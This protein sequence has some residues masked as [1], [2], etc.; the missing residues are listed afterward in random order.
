MS[1]DLA[2]FCKAMDGKWEVVRHEKNNEG[3]ITVHYRSLSNPLVE[4]SHNPYH[5]ENVL[6][7]GTIGRMGFITLGT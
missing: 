7:V 2:T 6:P 3:R 1:S 5:P 4:W